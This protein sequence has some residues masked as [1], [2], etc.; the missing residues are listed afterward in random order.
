MAPG[1]T[2]VCPGLEPSELDHQSMLLVYT[3]VQDQEK[4]SNNRG[5]LAEVKDCLI[6]IPMQHLKLFRSV[7]T[8]IVTHLVLSLSL[9]CG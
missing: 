6:D 8:A 7:Q 1:Q 4:L 5:I 9:F 2:F 3:C